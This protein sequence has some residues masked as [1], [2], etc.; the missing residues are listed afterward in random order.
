MEQNNISKEDLAY[1]AG[2]FDGEGCVFVTLLNKRN[3]ILY[4]I[5]GSL[6]IS[7][8]NLDVLQWCR[9]VLKVGHIVLNQNPSRI[10]KGHKPCYRFILEQRDACLV[11]PLFLPFLMIKNKQLEHFLSFFESRNKRP[12]NSAYNEKELYHVFECKRLLQGNDDFIIIRKE[13]YLFED[14][15]NCIFDARSKS[16]YKVFEWDQRSISML[17]TDIDGAIAKKLGVKRHV[18]QK[19]RSD[20][21][22]KPFKTFRNID[23]YM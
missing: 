13:K 7:N 19:K 18:V 14:F 20:L 9:K 11:A 12:I 3:K 5:S 17:G 10:N 23:V 4:T 15:V 1:I 8:T 2:L 21:K 6:I 22:I 16:A